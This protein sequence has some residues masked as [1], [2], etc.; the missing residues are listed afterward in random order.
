MTE[1][2]TIKILLISSNPKMSKEPVTASYP[3]RDDD[4]A[5]GGAFGTCHHKLSISMASTEPNWPITKK[6]IS[7]VLF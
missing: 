7:L 1:Y 2:L 6:T 3:S 4:K 5:T